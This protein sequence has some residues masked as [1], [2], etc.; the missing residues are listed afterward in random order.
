MEQK[1]SPSCCLTSELSRSSVF[2]PSSCCGL[3]DGL[4]PDVGLR[5]HREGREPLV[6]PVFPVL[7]T[8]AYDIQTKGR[9]AAFPV[10]SP[11]RRALKN[12]G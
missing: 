8:E 10:L 1:K 5:P 7:N 4:T 11:Q 6:F 12:N 9:N 2:P 3:A